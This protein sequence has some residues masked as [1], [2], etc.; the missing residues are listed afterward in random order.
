[1]K[2]EST[3]GW[4]LV[5]RNRKQAPRLS[6]REYTGIIMNAKSADDA[7]RV[8]NSMSQR[9]TKPN[10][11]NYNAT[12]SACSNEGAWQKA[13]VLLERMKHDGVEPDVVSYNSA[14]AA[15]GNGGRW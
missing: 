5:E 4:T 12:I 6:S 7:L 9:G 2:T 14:V 15:C 11:F 1:M 13:T 8:L 10:I 3:N